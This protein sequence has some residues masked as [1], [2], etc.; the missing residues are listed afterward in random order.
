MFDS[1]R[2]RFRAVATL[3]VAAALALGGVAVAQ[4]DSQAGSLGG[5]GARPAGPPPGLPMKGLTYAELHVQ[6]DGQAQTIRLDQGKI[7]TVDASSITLTENDGGSVTI[8]LDENTKVM[9]RPGEDATVDDLEAGQLV[10]V[11]G[12][13]GGA[14]KSVMVLPKPGQRPEASQGQSDS[15]GS[16]QSGPQGPRQGQLPPPPPGGPQGPNGD[17]G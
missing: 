6:R 14:A 11:C 7:A 3:G 5:Q 8:A 13:E 17:D 1:V 12:P 10:L 16:S 9:T 15:Q 2:S 4:G